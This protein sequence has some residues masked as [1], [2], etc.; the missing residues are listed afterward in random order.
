VAQRQMVN[1][2]EKM[3][4]LRCNPTTLTGDDKAALN[5]KLKENPSKGIK[6][7]ISLG[8]SINKEN[9]PYFLSDNFSKTH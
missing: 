2:V 9:L 6:I 5:E 7:L 3:C 4:R 1:T 8:D